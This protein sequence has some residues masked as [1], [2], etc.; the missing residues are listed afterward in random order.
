MKKLLVLAI[1][2]RLL[3]SAFFFHPDIKTFNFQ[4]SFLKK[5]VFNIYSYLVNNK[6]TLPLKEDFVYFP[7]TYFTLGGYQWATSPILGKGFDSWL[8]NADSNTI[9][10]NQNIFKYLTVLKLP[11]LIFDIL[12]AYFLLNYFENK[13]KGKKAFIIWLFNPITIF[14]IYAFGNVDIFPVAITLLSL[15]LIKK[16]KMKLGALTLGLAAGFKLYPLLFVP[17]LALS[18]KTL[19]E[20]IMLA[21]IPFLVFAGI[22]LPF[23]SSSFIQSTLISGLTTRMFF[24]NFEIGFNESIIVGLLGITVLFF[25]AALIDKKK[26]LLHYWLALFLIIFAF[27]HFHIAWLLWTAP[28]LVLLIVKRPQ[29]SLTILAISVCAFIIPLL[30][31]DRFMTLGLV[32]TYS[33]YYD[34]VPTPFTI[35]QKVFDPYNLQSILHSLIAGGTLVVT[36]LLFK[37]EE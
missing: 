16:G 6:K 8:A 2:L 30:Y 24:P 28:F 25:Y 23:I 32:R 27:A 9:V 4:A 26:N 34:L 18:G 29:L 31:Q 17:F 33:L 11:Y 20:K 14:I 3:V 19:K 10:T 37:K 15:L 7:L 21:V 22:S 36:Y 13:E 12:I 35:I 1:F 5:G